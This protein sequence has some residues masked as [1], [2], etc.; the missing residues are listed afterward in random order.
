MS[1]Q[2]AKTFWKCSKCGFTIEAPKPPRSCPTCRQECEFKDTTCYLPEC[3]GP[4]NIDPR[5]IK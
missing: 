4:G 1:Q 5:L 2:E 3:G